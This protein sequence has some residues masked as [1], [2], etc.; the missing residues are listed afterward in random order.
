MAIISDLAVQAQQYIDQVTQFIVTPIL[1]VFIGVIAGKI[2]GKVTYKIS[3]S[4]ELDKHLQRSFKYQAD[5]SGLAAG[6]IAAII[7]TVAIIWALVYA[8]AITYALI[9]LGIFL[10][11][12]L[13]LSVALWVRDF[14]GNALIGRVI[15]SQIRKGDSLQVQ[16]V[17]GEVHAF[18]TTGVYVRTPDEDTIIIPYRTVQKYT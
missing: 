4:I 9:I 2:L 11:T 18:A 3:Q 10:G 17:E 6:G 8:R 7:Y 15:R 16:G 5:Y 13:L 14:V 12:L 1:I